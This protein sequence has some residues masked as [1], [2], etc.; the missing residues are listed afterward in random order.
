MKADHVDYKEH[1]QIA[2]AL[3][4]WFQSQEVDTISAI[5]VMLELSGLAIASIASKNAAFEDSL[6]G[7]LEFLSLAAKQHFRNNERAQ[8]ER[9]YTK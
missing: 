4:A 7:S 9:S 8:S 5:G 2:Q 1:L 3:L 6:R